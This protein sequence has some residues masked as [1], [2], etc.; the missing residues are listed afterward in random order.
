M[1]IHGTTLATNALIERK[2]ARTAM[3][4]TEGFRDIIEQ[5]Y[6]KR[7][8]YD[9]MIDRPEPLVPRIRRYTIRERLSAD[10]DVLMPLDEGAVAAIGQRL[11]ADQVGAVAICLLHA[12]AHDRHERRVRDLLR[13]LLRDS[14]TICLSSEVAPRSANMSASRRPSP[15]PMCG[16]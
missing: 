11:H 13:P 16:R 15:T 3:I 7:F 5:G 6:E 9:L 8:D 1:L 14:V 10:G 4:T 12:Y 2:G